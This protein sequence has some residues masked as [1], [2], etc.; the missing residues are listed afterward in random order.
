MKKLSFRQLLGFLA[1][2]LLTMAAGAIAVMLTLRTMAEVN[3]DAARH[4]HRLLA[5]QQLLADVQRHRLFV[6]DYVATLKPE[7]LDAIG[8]QIGALSKDLAAREAWREVG[9]ARSVYAK[10]DEA[11]A[12]VL[13]LHYDFQTKKAAEVL[14]GTA[15]QLFTAVTQTLDETL[16]ALAQANLEQANQALRRALWLAAG[17]IVFAGVC[18]FPLAWGTSRFVAAPVRSASRDLSLATEEAVRDASVLETG[19]Q[20]LAEGTSTVASALEETSASVSTFADTTEKAS[21]SATDAASLAKSVARSAQEGASR[22]QEMT[23]AMQHIEKGGT[24]IRE[25]L[26]TIEGIAFQTNLL[27]LNAAVEAARAGEAGAGFAVVADEVRNLARRASD[28]ARDSAVQIEQSLQDTTRGTGL[29]SALAASITQTSTDVG[30][31]SQ[32]VEVVQ[33]ACHEQVESI[34][35]I[36]RAIEQ[37][38][39]HMQSNAAQAEESGCAGKSLQ[40]QLS[41]MS[42]VVE[43]LDQMTDNGGQ[44][45]N[46]ESVT[47]VMSGAAIA[48]GA[49]PR[50][51]GRLGSGR[52][53]AATVG[54]N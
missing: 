8:R 38:N 6:F 41:K 45:R 51:A 43:W 17:I 39:Q 35:Q 2:G 12:S 22:M 50:I 25:I 54:S 27:A 24:S 19:S 10:L 16:T 40:T 21:R 18:G 1:F 26:K 37:I 46:N 11:Y 29:T 44:V 3:E 5:V 9:D 4:Q 34:K 13:K 15:S 31:I 33:T 52:N 36:N 53:P 28:A 30:R 48:F 7:Q 42:A 49:A 14:N 23:V 32:L 20:T 47:P